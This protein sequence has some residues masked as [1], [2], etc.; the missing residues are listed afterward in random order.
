MTKTRLLND[1]NVV[2]V[3]KINILISIEQ[4]MMSNRVLKLTLELLTLNITT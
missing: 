3:N 2:L 4:Y 1:K